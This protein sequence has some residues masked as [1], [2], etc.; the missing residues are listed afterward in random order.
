MDTANATRFREDFLGWADGNLRTFP[1]RDPEAPLYEVFV[2]EFFLSRTRSEVV[3]RVYPEFI[4][5]Y[6]TLDSLRNVDRETLVDIIR[7]LGMQNRRADALE[8]IPGLVGESLPR[9]LNGLLELP[10]VGRYVANATL[11]FALDYQLP[12]VDRNVNRVY[13]RVLDDSWDELSDD[14]RWNLA[15]EL[16]PPG[17][18][19]TYNLALL[20]FASLIC[21]AQ[22]PECESCF[23]NGYCPYYATSV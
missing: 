6:P 14:E 10:Q 20:D 8:Q 4:E 17:D 9:T 2:A 13:R 23:A 21:K 22:S 12:I 19:R 3:G 11:C 1:W 7:P 5:I 15:A 16:L 18:A